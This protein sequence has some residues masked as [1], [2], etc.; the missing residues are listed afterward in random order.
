MS[1]TLTIEQPLDFDARYKVSGYGGIAFWL[2]RYSTTEEYEGDYLIC[3]DEDCDHS[4]GELCWTEGDTS[5]VT[6]L[7]WVIAVMVG[8]DREHLV[9]VGELTVIADEDYCHECGQIGCTHDGR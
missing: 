1:D 5:I 4:L 2:K 3:E 6:D 9:E 7:D 8:D